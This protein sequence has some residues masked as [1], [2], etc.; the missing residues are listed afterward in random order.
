MRVTKVVVRVPCPSRGCKPD[1][2]EILRVSNVLSYRSCI[3]TTCMFSSARS[4]AMRLARCRWFIQVGGWMVQ[5]PFWRSTRASQRGTSIGKLG[6]KGPQSPLGR[7]MRSI[8]KFGVTVMRE[9]YALSRVCVG[10][11]GNEQRGGGLRENRICESLTHHGH[12]IGQGC[13]YASE[14]SL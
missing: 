14:L 10:G 2:V 6:R 13:G 12:K 5:R 4:R 3:L 8:R 1:G 11:G 7:R 9:S